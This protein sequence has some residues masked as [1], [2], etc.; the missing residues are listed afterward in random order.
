MLEVDSGF[1]GVRLNRL[2]DVV[3]DLEDVLLF[4]GRLVRRNADAVDVAA[5]ADAC[6]R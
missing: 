3:D 2:A 1:E 6:S 5:E 4:I